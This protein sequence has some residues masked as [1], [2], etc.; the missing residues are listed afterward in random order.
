MNYNIVTDNNGVTVSI[1]GPWDYSP[2][3][4]ILTQS[5]ENTDTILGK[6]KN[7]EF[8]LANANL[9]LSAGDEVIKELSELK[10]AVGSLTNKDLWN[11]SDPAY[12]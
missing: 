7:I 10:N 9:R 6:I 2:R 4:D 5:K 1:R 11:M 8:N 3:G 12:I